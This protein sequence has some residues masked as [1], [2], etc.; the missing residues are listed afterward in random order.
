MQPGWILTSQSKATCL[1]GGKIS[2]C[3][4]V[5]SLLQQF[6]CDRYL[7]G[8]GNRSSS[9]GW[10]AVESQDDSE[11]R[12]QEESCVW[13][14]M[15]TSPNW[16]TGSSRVESFCCCLFFFFELEDRVFKCA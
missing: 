1:L 10:R 8:A 5:I 15:A 7:W 14:W 11:G 12:S 2:F 16:S 6:S 3:W 4:N 13:T 9:S